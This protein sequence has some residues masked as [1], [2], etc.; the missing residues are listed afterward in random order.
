[1]VRKLKICEKCLSVGDIRTSSFD[2]FCSD[3]GGVMKS[4][5]KINGV[6]INYPEGAK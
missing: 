3:C 2:M 5:D 6:V 1:M 4:V